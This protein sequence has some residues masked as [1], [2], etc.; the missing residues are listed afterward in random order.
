[1][2]EDDGGEEESLAGPTGPTPILMR[3]NIFEDE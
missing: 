3:A 1:M 2:T